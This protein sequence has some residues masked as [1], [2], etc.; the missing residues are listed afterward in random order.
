MK[1]DEIPRVPTWSATLRAVAGG[2][3]AVDG[4]RR[5]AHQHVVAVQLRADALADDV[6][7]FA[8]VGNRHVLCF[9]RATMAR[10]AGWVR[11][12]SAAAAMLNTVH[13]EMSGRKVWTSRTCGLPTVSVPVLSKTIVSTAASS[14][15]ARPP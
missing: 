15:S 12:R 1:T 4:E 3:P 7:R 10:A 8:S 14:S 5:T 9:S 13:S 2:A 11:R 6:L